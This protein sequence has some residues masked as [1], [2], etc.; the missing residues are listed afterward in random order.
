MTIN[1]NHY[2]SG[3][4]GRMATAC[5]LLSGC[6]TV[7]PP[8]ANE[9]AAPEFSIENT[10]TGDFNNYL[11]TWQQNVDEVDVPYPN[12][13]F[14]FQRLDA[15]VDVGDALLAERRVIGQ[16]E[17]TVRRVLVRTPESTATRYLAFRLVEGSTVPLDRSDL[18]RDAACDI[19]WFRSAETFTAVDIDG[20]CPLLEDISALRLTETQ[21]TATLGG[22][23]WD[24][25]KARQFK[26]WMGV[27]RQRWD[28]TAAD[29]DWVFM[30]KFM[31]HNEGQIVQLVEKD[32]SPTGYAIQLERL[33]YQNTRTPV[34][35]LGLVD[36]T[37]QKTITYTWSEP[38]SAL[39]GMNLRW[40]QVGLTALDE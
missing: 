20:G 2:P 34:L 19:S 14:G 36:E 30:S 22:A 28:Q 3:R 18:L 31:I 16:P 6:A 26:G 10:L 23:K 39:L 40:F 25:K 4:A 32:G 37:S 33:V 21:L 27:K 7:P 12:L 13:E 8:T 38:G 24:F 11:Q 35:K 5:L 29:D 15:T 1:A 17:L 9:V